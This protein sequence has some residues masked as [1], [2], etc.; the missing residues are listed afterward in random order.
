MQTRRDLWAGLALFAIT[1][2]LY[3]PATGFGFVAFDD[4]LYVYE[5]PMVRAGISLA[6]IKW[7]FTAVVAANWHPLTVISLML[8]ESVF[9]GGAAG[10]HLTNLLLHAADTVLLFVVLRRM[11]G[12]FWPAVLVAALF[13][14]HPLNVESVAWVAERKNVLSTLFLLLSL[15]CYTNYA[16]QKSAGQHLGALGF[17]AMGLTAKPMLVSLPL[18]LLL[19]DYWPL[20]RISLPPESESRAPAIRMALKLAAEKAPFFLLS[21][22]VCV[23]TM[24]AQTTAHSVKSLDEVPLALRLLNVPVAYAMYLAKTAWPANLCAFYP[25]PLTLPVQAAIGSL[26]LLAG[27]SVT[28]FYLRVRFRWLLVGWLWF[29]VTLLPVIGIVQTGTQASA[30]RHTY[31]PDLGLFLAVAFG[32]E[33]WMQQ[34]PPV[35]PWVFGSCAVILLSFAAATAVQLQY[36]HDSVSLFTRAVTVTK[37]NYNMENNLGVV[38]SQAGRSEEAIAHY[39]AAIRSKPTDLESQYHLGQ[40]LM[41][42]GQYDQAEAHF[43]EALKQSPGNVMLV[44]NIG[45]AEIM[46]GKPGEARDKFTQAMRLEPNYPKSYFNLALLDEQAGQDGAAATNFLTALR[47]DPDW[48]EA[49]NRAALFQ[50]VCPD[51][52]WRDPM[53]ALKF[54]RRAN[55][56][57]EREV[58][59]YL[60]TE[61]ACEA[62]NGNFSNAVAVAKMA[63]QSAQDKHLD[64]LADKL[65][66][67][68]KIYE[69]GRIPTNFA[70]VLSSTTGRP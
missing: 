58:P 29:L 53:N 31:V 51:M 3:W 49:L 17:F 46:Q 40:E 68:I 59:A 45:V 24:I 4:G 52:R 39:E 19:L 22:A 56:L 36:W 18:I 20:R 14:W 16:R 33:H 9:G 50:V 27:I 62:I 66:Q 2:F 34:R 7:A 38:L 15:W 13:G 37:D 43:I 32:L 69:S 5:N 6:G 47:L 42:V 63:E 1:A 35:R 70:A 61:G 11:T 26:V 67:E 25:L 60:E 54:S 10:Y 41:A 8:D 65:G 21:A 48:P 30:D 55:Q 28:A 23:V 64:A 57:T 44:N 12:A